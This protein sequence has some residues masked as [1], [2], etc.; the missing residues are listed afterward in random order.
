MTGWTTSEEVN[1]R[2]YTCWLS[3]AWGNGRHGPSG[4]AITLNTTE[5]WP[6]P[7]FV[8]VYTFD[9]AGNE[10]LVPGMLRRMAAAIV[11]DAYARGPE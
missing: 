4:K 3:P 8:H 2:R 10:A 6:A 11:E 9:V 7:M 5:R 1:G